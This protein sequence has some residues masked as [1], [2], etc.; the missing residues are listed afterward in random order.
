MRKIAVIFESSP[1]DRKGLFNA[2]HNRTRHLTAA[3]EFEVHAYCMHIYDSFLSRKLRKTAKVP[4]EEIVEVD[5][6][7]Y[8]MLWRRFSFLDELRRRVSSHSSPKDLLLYAFNQASQFKDYDILVAHSY[9]AGL[10]AYE[11][12][13]Q[14][15]VPYT[16]TWHGSDVHTHPIKDE[17]RRLLTARIMEKAAVNFFVSGNLLETSNKITENAVKSVLYNGVS[18]G[19]ERYDNEAR[20]MCRANNGVESED[21]VVAYVG[22][23]HPVKNVEILPELFLRI[24]DNFEMFLRECPETQANL[25]FWI[26]GDGKLRSQIE[27][28]VKKTAGAQ[29]IFWGNVDTDRMSALMHCIDLLVLPSKN[30]GLPL[31]TLEALSCGASVVG[32]DVGGI[33]EVIGKE[34]CVPF[35]MNRDGTIDYMGD[36]FIEKMSQ[37]VVK[38]LFYPK[39]QILDPRF[40]WE[41]TA[42]TEI[43][44]LK[45]LKR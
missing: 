20:A 6:I 13:V 31:V 4:K 27:P 12:H 17:A 30:E 14:F 3:G 26:V 2:V 21:K 23:L 16:V 36:S 44:I 43:A 19:Y 40:S 11:A 7:S 9:E 29:V 10:V 22:N 5:G 15:G 34:F 45:T 42:K 39:E 24:H 37:K 25:K 41:E 28:I 8:K 1:F 35:D 33:P 18:E 38:Q 32:S